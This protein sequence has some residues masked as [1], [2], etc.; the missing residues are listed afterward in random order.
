MTRDEALAMEGTGWQG[1]QDADRQEE[2][3]VD[4]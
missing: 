1:D 4:L 2:D 3:V